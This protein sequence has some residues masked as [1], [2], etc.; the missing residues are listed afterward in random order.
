MKV[1]SLVMK[2]LEKRRR[3]AADFFLGKF[4]EGAVAAAYFSAAP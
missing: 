4:R 2:L 3:I 1:E